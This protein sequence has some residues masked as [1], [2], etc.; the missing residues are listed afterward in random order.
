MIK[1][2]IGTDAGIIWQL[3][4]EKNIL[5]ISEIEEHT[6]IDPFN[7]VLAIGW[8]ARENKIHFLTENDTLYVELISTPSDIYY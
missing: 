4:F 6:S 8:L 5:S 1:D 2:T 3:L 7:M